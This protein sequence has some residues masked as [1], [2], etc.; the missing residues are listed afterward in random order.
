MVT[1]SAGA[2][3]ALGIGTGLIV[4]VVGIITIALIATRKK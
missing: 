1:L 2:V 4:G 3:F